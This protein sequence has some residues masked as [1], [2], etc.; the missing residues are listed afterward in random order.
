MPIETARRFAVV[1]GRLAAVGMAV[2]VAESPGHR[3]VQLRVSPQ[4]RSTRPDDV[5][6]LAHLP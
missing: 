6:I 4:I 1:V 5:A 3:L 2:S